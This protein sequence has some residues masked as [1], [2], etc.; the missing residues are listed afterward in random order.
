MLIV[1]SETG[2]G[3][4]RKRAADYNLEHRIDDILIT[5]SPG[6]NPD[7]IDLPKLPGILFKDYNIILANHD[8][9][10]KVL[11]AFC[12]A[13][14]IDQFNFTFARKP[15]LYDAVK[16][17]TD[18]DDKTKK[19]VLNDFQARVIN[20]FDTDT[21]RMPETFPVAEIIID[22]PDEAA[23]VVLDTRKVRL[24]KEKKK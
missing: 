19:M 6:N 9:G 10:K 5:L 8:G 22:E 13:G 15:S 23:V 4:I 20:F 16:S 24:F 7:N 14:I 12:Q 21:G 3:K 17:S 11:E 2:A 1:T 18:I